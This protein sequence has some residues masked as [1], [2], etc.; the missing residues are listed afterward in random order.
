[1]SD[2]VEI[3]MFTEPG[4][5]KDGIFQKGLEHAFEPDEFYIK[6]RQA[7][8]RLWPAKES[9]KKTEVR[10]SEYQGA[11]YYDDD[12]VRIKQPTSEDE[13]EAVYI[14]TEE[15]YNKE[16]W[17]RDDIPNDAFQEFL[18]RHRVRTFNGEGYYIDGTRLSGEE[19]K[20]LG[21]TYIR[22]KLDY[23]TN[24]P[25]PQAVVKLSKKASLGK[26]PLGIMP[27]Y[28]WKEDRVKELEKAIQRRFSS[29]HEIP[30][31]WLTERN[32]LVKQLAERDPS[33]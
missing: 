3:Q 19:C 7:Y 5:Y 2:K 6:D 8:F 14:E 10:V 33:K 24:Y 23:D 1:M 26:P 18:N 28:L 29:F 25:P 16:E 20:T 32:E 9:G 17:D 4:V 21:G 30:P 22:T 12:G 27:D 13:K 11:G 15:Q 31:E